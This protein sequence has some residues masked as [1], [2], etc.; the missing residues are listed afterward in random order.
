M[1]EYG[2]KRYDVVKRGM[3]ISLSA[4]AL[5]VLAPFWSSSP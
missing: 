4:T 3:D 2:W 5:L 1:M